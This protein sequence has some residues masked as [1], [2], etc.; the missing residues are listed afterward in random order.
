MRTAHI[1][2]TLAVIKDDEIL[3][4]VKQ[5]LPSDLIYI[6]IYNETVGFEQGSYTFVF[7]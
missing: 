1:R 3:N 4:S 7:K 2:N 6:R 5:Y